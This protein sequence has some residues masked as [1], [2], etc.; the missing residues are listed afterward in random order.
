MVHLEVWINLKQRITQSFQ[1][2]TKHYN[3]WDS[4]WGLLLEYIK[5]YS[6]KNKKSHQVVWHT[7]TVIWQAYSGEG[8]INMWVSLVYFIWLTKNLVKN[9]YNFIKR[10]F[11]S[12][13]K[14]LVFFF[15]LSKTFSSL[16]FFNS[17]YIINWSI[18]V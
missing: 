5:K 9:Q 17:L 2:Y 3:L 6:F 11:I 4:C 10:Q 14:L 15:Y 8:F 12:T 18:I 16:M 7:E 13:I 1:D